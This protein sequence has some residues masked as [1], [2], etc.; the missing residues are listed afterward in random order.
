MPREIGTTEISFIGMIMY[1]KQ[2]FVNGVSLNFPENKL[3][4][5]DEN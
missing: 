5:R 4:W 1:K 3:K 2:G